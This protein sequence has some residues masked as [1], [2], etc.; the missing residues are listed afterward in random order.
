MDKINDMYEKTFMYEN[1]RLKI[2]ENNDNIKKQ[3]HFFFCR[4]ELNIC[5]RIASLVVY[6]YKCIETEDMNGCIQGLNYDIDFFLKQQD[7]KYK[8]SSNIR[9]DYTQVFLSYLNVKWQ[10]EIYVEKSP[11]ETLELIYKNIV[12]DNTLEFKASYSQNIGRSMLMLSYIYFY[13]DKSEDLIRIVESLYLYFMQTLKYILKKKDMVGSSHFGD[14][15]KCGTCLQYALMGVEYIQ[16]KRYLKAWNLDKILLLTLRVKNLDF[17]FKF[18]KIFSRK[19]Y[20]KEKRVIC[21][22]I[23]YSILDMTN[24]RQFHTSSYQNGLNYE[25]YKN[26]LFNPD[27]LNIRRKLFS[28]FCLH[29]LN[30]IYQSRGDVD[31]VV[32]LMIST[33]LPEYEKRY[34]RELTIDYP[35]LN[36]IECHP[37]NVNISNSMLTIL[38]KKITQEALVAT[39]RLD[40]D[41]ALTLEWLDSIKKIISND[42]I[43]KIYSFPNGAACFYDDV[44]DVII[45]ATRLFSKNIA[46]GLSC[47]SYF[48]NSLLSHNIYNLGNHMSLNSQIMVDHDIAF[49]RTINNFR[50]KNQ[51]NDIVERR[52]LKDYANYLQRYGK[53]DFKNLMFDNIKYEEVDMVLLKVALSDFLKVD[54]LQEFF[55]QRLKKAFFALYFMVGDKV[56]VKTKYSHKYNYC[57]KFKDHKV[58]PGDI[59]HIKIYAKYDDDI[60]YR[61]KIRIIKEKNIYY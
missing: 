52:L 30:M 17:S 16:N 9:N 29:S 32:V 41:D 36:I 46:L 8:T 18:E 6:L 40:D 45:G 56:V 50:D 57:L 1:D 55:S 51:K 11:I 23:R 19:D 10:A 27:R 61:K 34:L 25:N 39:V 31:I 38:K 4:T 7:S 2:Y 48:K 42:N 28:N 59:T 13:L 54:I 14:F 33:E 24:S 15:L 5:Y 20:I 53:I 26:K 60:I 22:G 37:Y 58:D 35:F 44:N 12:R 49:V 3:A 21:I 43:G 47:V